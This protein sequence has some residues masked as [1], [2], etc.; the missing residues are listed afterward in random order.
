MCVTLCVCVCV[1]TYF[2]YIIIIECLAFDYCFGNTSAP[3][4]RYFFCVRYFGQTTQNKLPI[5]NT[6]LTIVVCKYEIKIVLVLKR[7]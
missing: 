3:V 5:N 1:W 4:D 2:F 7:R 6:I